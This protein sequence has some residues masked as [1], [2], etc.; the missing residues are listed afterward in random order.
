[1]QARKYKVLLSFETIATDKIEAFDNAWEVV[2]DISKY[3]E[4]DLDVEDVVRLT[5]CGKRRLS[6]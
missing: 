1:M 5:K 2:H 6:K 4:I 3:A